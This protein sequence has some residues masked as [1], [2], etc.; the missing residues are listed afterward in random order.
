MVYL[1]AVFLGVLQ[2]LTEFFPVSSSGHLVVSRALLEPW[3][4]RI[5]A[6]L[7]FD[8][9]VHL[10][11]AIVTM[12]F[13]REELFFM[14]KRFFSNSSEAEPVRSLVLRLVVATVPAVIVGLFF[15]DTIERSFSSI[16]WAL[17]GFLFTALLLECAHRRQLRLQP[18]GGGI[19]VLDWKQPSCW[20]AA[21]IGFAQAVAIIPGVS[22]SGST[23]AAALILGLGPVTAVRFSFFMLLPVVFGGVVLEIGTLRSLDSQGWTALVLGFIASAVTA[24]FS[25]R[26]LVWLVQ[27][28]KLRWFAIYTLCLGL[29]LRLV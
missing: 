27:S 17:N 24:Y 10:A 23:I 11:T 13:L 15:R 2:G 18:S 14:L 26:A 8:I 5:D 20:Q 4:G 22:R 12:V 28:A 1:L 29:F 21:V 3:L 9:A 6:P 25:L 16:D 7:A 19:S